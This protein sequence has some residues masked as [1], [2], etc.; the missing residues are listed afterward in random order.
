MRYARNQLP[1]VSKDS[2]CQRDH[3]NHS[4]LLATV[5]YQAVGD[6]QNI[7]FS[8]VGSR[9][10]YIP[11]VNSPLFSYPLIACDSDDIDPELYDW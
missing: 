10:A 4:S 6:D 7:P 3:L 11:E 1:N 8:E 2:W 5:R 9:N